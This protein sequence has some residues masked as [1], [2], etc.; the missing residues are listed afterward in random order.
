MRHPLAASLI[1]VISMA[2]LGNAADPTSKPAEDAKVTLARLMEAQRLAAEKME[3]ARKELELA[4]SARVVPGANQ[5][6]GTYIVL[7]SDA[8]KTIRIKEAQDAFDAAKGKLADASKAVADYR[9][10]LNKPASRPATRSATKPASAPAS[11]PEA[12]SKW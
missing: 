5:H 9:A 3:P 11:R 1:A 6:G 12:L 10:S 4:K 2:A 7:P 8:A